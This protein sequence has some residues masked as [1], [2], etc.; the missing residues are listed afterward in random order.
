MILSAFDMIALGCVVFIGL[1]HGAFDG[2]IYALLPDEITKQSRATSLARFLA[3]YTCLAGVIVVLWLIMPQLSLIAFLAISAFHFGKGDTEGYH[4]IA[5]LI[6]LIAHGGLV[7]LWLPL[8]HHEMAFSYFAALTFAPID[9]LS[10]LSAFMYACAFLWAI[11]VMAYGRMALTNPYY[12]GRFFEVLLLVPAMAYLPLLP[13]FALYFCAFHSRRHFVSLYHA[14][15]TSA[16]AQLYALGIGLSVASWVFG[17]IALFVL[18]QYQSFA[19]SAIQIIFIGLAALTVP[20]MILVDGLWRPL[21][22]SLHS[23]R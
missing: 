1:P 10:L 6:A 4:G 19:L 7:T 21:R 11:C 15:K 9:A 12:R 3:L 5:R 20:H 18:N 22:K 16:P 13:A 8:T 23:S 14:T 2:A 17:A